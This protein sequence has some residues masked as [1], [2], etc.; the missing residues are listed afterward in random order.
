MF[1]A[2]ACGDAEQKGVFYGNQDDVKTNREVPAPDANGGGG[3]VPVQ[4]G[5]KK[6][7]YL[8][9]LCGDTEAGCQT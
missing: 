6:L 1:K 4:K 5:K 9:A 7:G 3:V 8:S 2:K